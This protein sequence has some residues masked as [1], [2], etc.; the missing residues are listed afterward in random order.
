MTGVE[1]PDRGGVATPAGKGAG[2][3]ALAIMGENPFG[4][5]RGEMGSVGERRALLWIGRVGEDAVE[6]A[7][8]G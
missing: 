8:R 1:V 6:D 4:D 7:L 3:R 5:W 2:A